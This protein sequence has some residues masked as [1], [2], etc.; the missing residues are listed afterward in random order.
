MISSS[1]YDEL[2]IVWIKA[3]AVSHVTYYLFIFL[4][5]LRKI[6]Y[7]F[8]HESRS[9]NPCLNPE[10]LECEAAVRFMCQGAVVRIIL[11]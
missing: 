4:E 11:K 3:A 10:R 9:A 6:T 2:Q 1:V 5:K 8:D 7:N